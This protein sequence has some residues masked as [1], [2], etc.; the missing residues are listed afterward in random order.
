[1]STMRRKNKGP[2][3]SE[4]GV[5]LLL[6]LWVIVFLAFVCAEFSWT[7]RTETAA[8]I[9]FKEGTQALY[10]AEAG[11]NRSIIE[12]LRVSEESRIFNRSEISSDDEDDE[13]DTDVPDD[14]DDMDELSDEDMDGLYDEQ[15]LWLAG[16]G[17]YRFELG[18]FY[19]E[20]SIIDESN[21]ININDFLK[22]S[23]QDPTK[24]KSFLGEQLGLEGEELD[25]VA[26][27]LIDWWDKD[28]NV[29]GVFG[30]EDEYY[31]SLDPPYRSRNAD[32]LAIE[33]CLLVRGVTEEIF[34]GRGRQLEARVQLVPE[35][36]EQLLSGED[37]FAPL[38][39]EEE[40]FDETE[41]I[42]LRL[43]L[44]DV[45]SVTSNASSF[46]ININTA[47][48]EQLM[49]LLGMQQQSAQDIIAERTERLFDSSTDRLPQFANY[50][51][52]K[53]TIKVAQPDDLSNYSVYA[54]GFS[55][56][57]RVSRSIRCSLLVSSDE[58]IISDWRIDG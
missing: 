25:I 10:A 55:R 28:N 51:V 17:P 18:D 44:T 9:N 15:Q 22:Q 5:A 21:K 1:M 6:V 49:L 35:E 53:D 46:E 19:C 33:E 39:D 8:A 4:R 41:I 16:G 58:C 20:V 56:D 50:E 40:D 29:T 37:L 42:P 2:L 14:I 3:T 23:A 32:M 24:L 54:R 47:S 12:L 34:Y 13:D 45:F 31:E 7:M 48:F 52:W 57:G 11:I 27:S 36:L 26:D 30:T 38:D 43:G